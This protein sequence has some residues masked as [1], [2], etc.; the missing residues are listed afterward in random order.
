M[1]VCSMLCSWLDTI[2][3]FCRFRFL[4]YRSRILVD[5]VKKSLHGVSYRNASPRL[6]GKGRAQQDFSV[7][8]P[9]EHALGTV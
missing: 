3:P 8:V 4:K 2:H 5:P 7:N 9:Q 6:V 1:H